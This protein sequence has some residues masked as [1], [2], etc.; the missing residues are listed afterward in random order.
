MSGF[1]IQTPLEIRFSHLCSL[2]TIRVVYDFFSRQLQKFILEG[3]PRRIVMPHRKYDTYM[4]SF[5]AQEVAFP[6]MSS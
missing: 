6:E 2:F 3:P 5:G 1:L 4:M